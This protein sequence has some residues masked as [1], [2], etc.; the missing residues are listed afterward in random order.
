MTENEKDSNL[1]PTG[2]GR[3]T[4]KRKEREAA[5]IKPIVGNRSKEAVAA[6]RARQAKQRK[7]QRAAMLAGDERYL[8]GR[9]RGP[10]RKIVREVLDNRFTFIEGLL[11]IMIVFLLFSNMTSVENQSIITFIMFGVLGI[12]CLEVTWLNSVA[13]KRIREKMGTDVVIQKGTWFYILMRGM[14]PRPLRIPKPNKRRS[15]KK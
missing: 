5:N 9:D 1:K 10:Q 7:Q 12:C 4:P 3:P 11:L 2:K 13:R 6:A 15:V 8:L 14:Q